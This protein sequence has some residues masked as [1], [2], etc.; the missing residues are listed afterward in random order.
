MLDVSDS[1][2]VFDV[3]GHFVGYVKGCFHPLPRLFVTVR[4]FSSIVRYGREPCLGGSEAATVDPYTGY[5]KIVKPPSPRLLKDC[6]TRLCRAAYDLFI[7]ISSAVDEE[8][9]RVTGSLA[10]DPYKAS[11]ID[12]VVYGCSET[13]RAYKLL[14]DLRRDGITRPYK[15]VG[16]GWNSKD[17]GLHQGLRTER[18]LLGLFKGIPYSLRLVDCI[19]AWRCT[20][21]RVIGRCIKVRG[22]IERAMAYTTPSY[23]LVVLHEPLILGDNVVLKTLLIITHRLKFMEIPENT[24]IEVQG[25]LEEVDKSLYRLSPDH[26]GYISLVNRGS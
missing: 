24:L 17:I 22:R 10:V 3:Q 6:N 7:L 26:G 14:I 5:V 16:R 9:I 18:V 12:L 20:P 21:F 13:Y 23:Y 15:G 2:L 19:R 11:D 1:W 25:V 4:R 8:F